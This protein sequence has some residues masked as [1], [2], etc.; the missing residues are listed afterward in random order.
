M[1]LIL[2][3]MRIAVPKSYSSKVSKAV[4]CKKL[5]MILERQYQLTMATLS[6]QK[7]GKSRLINARLYLAQLRIGC[8]AW[9]TPLRYVG[10]W[11]TVRQNSSVGSVNNASLF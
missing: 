2:I 6:I 4:A 10:E 11:A 3:N 7:P 8:L 9:P 1:I 5:Q